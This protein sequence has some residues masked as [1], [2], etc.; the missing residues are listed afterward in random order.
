[1]WCVAKG[2]L[3]PEKTQETTQIR[4][5]SGNLLADWHTRAG[6]LVKNH[7]FRYIDVILDS[8]E[9]TMICPHCG[10]GIPD[11]SNFCTY[12]GTSLNPEASAGTPVFPAPYRYK[13]SLN[14]LF[15]DTFELYKRNFGTMCLLGLVMLGIPLVF[16]PFDM[17]VSFIQVAARTAE[18]H[19]L[20]MMAGLGRICLLILQCIL[21]WYIALGVLRQCLYL[22]KGGSGFQ[23]RM[24]FPPFRGF[25]KYVGLILVFQCIFLGILLLCALPSGI[26]ALV[27][28]CA[29]AFSD[30]NVSAN[31]MIPLTIVGVLF[32]IADFCVMIWFSMRLL[33]APVFLVERDAGIG[34]AIRNAWR[35]S[36]GNFWMLFLAMIVLS[37]GV[38]LGYCL[39][40]VGIILTITIIVLGTVLIYLQLTG[41][42]NGL[43]YSPQFP[44]LPIAFPDIE[45]QT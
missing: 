9:T 3:F 25:L 44:C 43:D 22:A 7:P 30:N 39:C 34:D 10:A 35:V 15:G 8:H 12:C 18:N 6:L 19:F 27:A 33:L 24:I 32:A 29:G 23:S 13:L 37:V 11:D 36:S 16:I 26:I 45:P 40:C 4:F 38:T 14:K 42:P 5:L 21:Q 31:I 20:L 41:Q 2:K 17:A 1:M 28:Y